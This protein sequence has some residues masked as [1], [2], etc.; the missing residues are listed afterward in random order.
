VLWVVHFLPLQTNAWLRLLD[1]DLLLAAASEE[2]IPAVLCGHTHGPSALLA[3]PAAPGG[4]FCLCGST[5]QYC[6]PNGNWVNLLDITIT[7]AEATP[8]LTLHRYRYD[9]L[10][11]SFQ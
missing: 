9:P 3:D 6:E 2:R 10:S 4:R 11:G 8:T 1:A 7:L 5:T